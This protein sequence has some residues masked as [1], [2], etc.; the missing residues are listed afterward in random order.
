MYQ[1]DEIWDSL[2]SWLKGESKYSDVIISSR[3]RL[4]RNLEN[5]P[6][7][8][9]ATDKKLEKII[10]EFQS[11]VEENEFFSNMKLSTRTPDVM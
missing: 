2:P 6:F 8:N 4:A 11:V 1:S 9:N 7:P 5:F 3:I 10:N